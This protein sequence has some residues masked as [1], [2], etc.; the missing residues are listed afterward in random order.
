MKEK[1]W[2]RL[3]EARKVNHFTQLELAEKMGIGAQTYMRWENLSF[4]PSI[5]QLK[6]LSLI[7]NVPIDYLLYN[8]VFDV[9]DL[10]YW[11]QLAEVRKAYARLLAEH[12]GGLGKYQT[13]EEMIEFIANKYAPGPY[14]INPESLDAK[15]VVDEDTP[16]TPSIFETKK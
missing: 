1:K 5:R 14:S 13:K 11:M 2:T 8:D 12:P 16:F 10:D 6:S 15:V 4:E 3:I 7:L 9:G